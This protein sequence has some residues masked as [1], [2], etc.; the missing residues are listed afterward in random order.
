[1]AWLRRNESTADPAKPKNRKKQAVIGITLFA[2]VIAAGLYLSSDS[3]ADRV[4]LKVIAKLEEITGGRVELKKFHWNL[5]KLQFEADDLTIHGLEPAGEIPYAH[6]DH[7]KIQVKIVA[8]FSGEIGLRYAGFERPVIHIMVMSDGSTNQPV[9]MVQRENKGSAVDD[10]FRLAMERFE[11]RDSVLLW[12]DQRMP[13]D[14]AGEQLKSTITYDATGNKYDGSVDV[15]R[16]Q[17]KYKDLRPMLS[18]AEVEFSLRPS[19]IEV[20]TLHWSS[21]GS[22]FVAHGSVKNFADPKVE[23]AYRALLDLQQAGDVLQLPT[24][25]GGTVEV[26]GEGRYNLK[27]FASS[28]K[29]LVRNLHYQD[30]TVDVAGIHGGTDFSV[31]PKQI[32]FSKLQLRVFGGSISGAASVL[33]WSTRPGEPGKTPQTGSGHFKVDGVQV[34]SAIQAL[35]HNVA[36]AKLVGTAEGTVDAAWNGTPARAHANIAVDVA[37]PAQPAPDAIPVTAVLRAE[38]DLASGA[39]HVQQR[40]L[41]TRTL[42]LKPASRLGRPK[43]GHRL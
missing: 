4:R 34:A 20:K 36:A 2:L 14:L 35:A 29:M 17:T 12:N 31:T 38:Y 15:G 32:A 7:L 3:F 18:N 28:G 5:T 26:D 6:A 30:A 9:P 33:D 37:P 22:N 11:L 40:S 23:L 24:L 13:F 42:Q 43:S 27:D 1:M 21:Q 41:A 16:L 25:R 39:K 8:L 19:A 10:L